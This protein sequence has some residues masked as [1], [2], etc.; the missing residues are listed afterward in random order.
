[1]TPSSWVTVGADGVVTLP[2][3]VT[4][5]TGRIVTPSLWVTEGAEEVVTPPL[6]VTVGTDGVVTPSSWLLFREYI[7][8]SKQLSVVCSNL[9]VAESMISRAI[10]C[11]AR[12]WKLLN[13]HA[14]RSWPGH[15]S[16]W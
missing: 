8:V 11:M 14:S 5:G 9:G 2:L 7:F 6:W 4:V 13:L 10:F 3:R 16:C 12:I 15:T 1:M